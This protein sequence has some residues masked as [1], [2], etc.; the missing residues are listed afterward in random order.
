VHEV[1]FDGYRVQLHKRDGQVTI[2][3]RNGS[4]FTR[5]YPMIEQALHSLPAK[6]F[7]ID[8]ELVACDLQGRPD[9]ATLHKGTASGDQLNVYGFD[10]LEHNGKGRAWDAGGLT[11]YRRIHNCQSSA[12]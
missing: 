10:P 8:G 5:R 9:F 12:A 2:Y 4:D 7:V 3:S 6:A 1:K 11:H